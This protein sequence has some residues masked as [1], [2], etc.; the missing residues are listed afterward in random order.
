MPTP[1]DLEERWR[2]L[3]LALRAEF[4]DAGLDANEDL[5]PLFALRLVR[6]RLTGAPGAEEWLSLT[7]ADDELARAAPEA[8]ARAI[9]AAYRAERARPV[10]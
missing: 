3:V 2:A 1:T 8:L 6:G 4:W 10:R 5:F 7:V 9:F